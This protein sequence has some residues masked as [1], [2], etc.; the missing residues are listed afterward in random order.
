VPAPRYLKASSVT[1]LVVL[2][3]WPERLVGRL[4]ALSRPL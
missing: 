3:R 4:T 1:A 2:A